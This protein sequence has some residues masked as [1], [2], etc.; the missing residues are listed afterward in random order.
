M[1]YLKNKHLTFAEMQHTLDYYIFHLLM[2]NNKIIHV[3]KTIGKFKSQQE[4]KKKK[5]C[6]H[7]YIYHHKYA[8]QEHIAYCVHIHNGYLLSRPVYDH[9]VPY[10]QIQ[11]LTVILLNIA[12][13]FNYV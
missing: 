11:L 8:Y 12:F 7:V 6:F 13:I 2:H 10:L 3:K 4:R 5:I 9:I 1:F